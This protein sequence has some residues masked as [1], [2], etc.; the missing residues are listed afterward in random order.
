M[1]DIFKFLIMLT[2]KLTLTILTL[3]IW[4]VVVIGLVALVIGI[5]SG[6]FA[7]IIVCGTCYVFLKSMKPSYD[8]TVPYVIDKA[9]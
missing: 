7:I 9:V 8:P 1:F 6:W 4:L 3:S 2:T 5:A